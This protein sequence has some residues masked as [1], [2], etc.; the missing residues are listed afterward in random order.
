MIQHR[1]E[2]LTNPRGNFGQKRADP[3]SATFKYLSVCC[4]EGLGIF[5][6]L[7]SLAGCTSWT[8][9]EIPTGKFLF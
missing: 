1:M 7:M 6:T 5:C 2:K 3:G 8:E 9:W 4:C